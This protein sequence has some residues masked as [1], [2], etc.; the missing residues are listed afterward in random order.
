M[1][2]WPVARLL[3]PLQSTQFDAHRAFYS[4]VQSR[5]KIPGLPDMHTGDS[6][7]AI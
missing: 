5:T 1:I 2:L 4:A 3:W 6:D 7:A